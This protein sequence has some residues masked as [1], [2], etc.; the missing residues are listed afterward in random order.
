MYSLV[1]TRMSQVAPGSLVSVTLCA[2]PFF[3]SCFIV[4]VIAET[5]GEIKAI[6]AFSFLTWIL[7]SSFPF[8]RLCVRLTV[9][10]YSD[11]LLHRAPGTGYPRSPTG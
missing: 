6:M 4:G 1:L 5:C 7:R 3:D 9:W 2:W 11:Y 8:D 10:S